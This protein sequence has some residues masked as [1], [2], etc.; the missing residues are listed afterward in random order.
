MLWHLAHWA[1][2]LR[3]K[4]SFRPAW[5]S[6]EMYG[7]QVLSDGDAGQAA[8]VGDHLADLV[9]LERVAQL[10]HGGVGHAVLDRAGD[11]GVGAAVEPLV[12]GQVGPLAAAAGPA[13]TAAAQAA[14]QRLALGQGRRVRR[15]R[16]HGAGSAAAAAAS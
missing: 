14:E 5:G 8:D 7:F 9:G 13:V 16:G 2:P 15:C 3:S 12:V 11:V 1:L 10:L 6:P 4:K